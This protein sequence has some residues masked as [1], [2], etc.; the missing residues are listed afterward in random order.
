MFIK[1][2]LFIVLF[3]IGTVTNSMAQE[4]KVKSIKLLQDADVSHLPPSRIDL[5]GNQCAMLKVVARDTIQRVEGNYIGNVLNWEDN[6]WIYVTAGTT[7]LKIFFL[8]HFPLMLNF[9]D[10]GIRAALSGN[11]YELLIDNPVP[12]TVADIVSEHVRNFSVGAVTFKMVEV[13]GGTFIMGDTTGNPEKFTEQPAHEVT[14]SSYMIG[15]TEV[16]QALWTAVMDSNPSCNNDTEDSLPVENV[17]W[18]DCQE[19]LKRL[20]KIT[21]VTFRLPT[22]AEWE[23]AAHGGS[24]SAGYRFS[25]SNKLQDVSWFINNSDNR[26]HPVGQKQPN[27]L[28]IYDMCGN[29][30]EW[31]NDWYSDYGKKSQFNPQGA[32]LKKESV[33]EKVVRGGTYAYDDAMDEVTFRIFFSPNDRSCLQGLRLALSI[34]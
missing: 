1:R 16:T 7:T 15:Q 32:K 21:G 5:I 34:Y 28:G 9:R 33:G 4:Y 26:S 22:E 29:V 19:F 11:V 6:Q 17:S 20:N 12:A 31:C 27:E 14:L 13:D 8:H 18:Y 30:C 3:I 10:Y 2:Y 24:R 25:G 23:Y